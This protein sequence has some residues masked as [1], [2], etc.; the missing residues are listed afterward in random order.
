MSS[1][2]REAEACRRSFSKCCKQSHHSA[3]QGE[4]NLGSTSS[5]AATLCAKIFQK[6]RT[7]LVTGR[8]ILSSAP[9][10]WPEGTGQPGHQESSDDSGKPLLESSQ[11][12]ESETESTEEQRFADDMLRASDQ[13]TAL[14]TSERDVHK[15]VSKQ[16][17]SIPSG[18]TD[19]RFN[20]TER[21]QLKTVDGKPSSIEV[22]KNSGHESNQPQNTGRTQVKKTGGRKR[23]QKA[24]LNDR[25]PEAVQSVKRGGIPTEET[26]KAQNTKRNIATDINKKAQRVV[27]G[28]NG[29][30]KK[31]PLLAYTQSQIT[32]EVD[33]NAT[34]GTDSTAPSRNAKGGTK[35]DSRAIEVGKKYGRQSS[36]LRNTKTAQVKMIAKTGDKEQI[37]EA[38][39]LGSKT[40]KTAKSIKTDV[41]PTGAPSKPKKNKIPPTLLTKKVPSVEKE[42]LVVQVPKENCEPNKHPAEMKSNEKDGTEGKAPT[43]KTKKEAQPSRVNKSK[44][45]TKTKSDSD[46]AA[47]SRGFLKTEGKEAANDGSEPDQ[48]TSG[49]KT[50]GWLPDKFLAYVR[51]ADRGNV[52]EILVDAQKTQDGAVEGRTGTRLEK[53]SLFSAERKHSLVSTIK[54]VVRLCSKMLHILEVNKTGAKDDEERQQNG[55]GSHDLQQ[56]H[57]IQRDPEPNSSKQGTSDEFCKTISPNTSSKVADGTLDV[58]GT[59]ARPSHPPPL[60]HMK[61]VEKGDRTLSNHT[62]RASNNGANDRSIWQTPEKKTTVDASAGKM[63][64]V[65]RHGG[66]TPSSGTFSWQVP[67]DLLVS[68]GQR[69]RDLKKGEPFDAAPTN[70]PRPGWKREAAAS[71]NLGGSDERPPQ[72]Q[73]SPFSTDGPG[74]LDVGPK[75]ASPVGK[76][77]QSRKELWEKRGG[78]HIP[79]GAAKFRRR[80]PAGWQKRRTMATGPARLSEV[81]DGHHPPSSVSGGCCDSSLGD[82]YW[83]CQQG[84]SGKVRGLMRTYE[85]PQLKPRIQSPAER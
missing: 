50:A 27:P 29:E 40:P 31:S 55:S 30:S 8:D 49:N 13:D 51:L 45:K 69:L 35:R 47:K 41:L 62:T 16:P 38:T 79:A 14:F 42:G 39:G 63:Q 46:L 25:V 34:D 76:L 53:T 68:G 70:V 80:L 60:P 2:C 12:Q 18:K 23:S 85:T 4:D 66:E 65:P 82:D 48:N 54:Q 11:S 84:R 43:V 19:E 28:E 56:E 26:S 1:G 37:N 81:Q 73:H 17:P 57:I 10:W 75:H 71:A 67:R 21:T 59:L 5:T 20:S 72:H 78:A 32:A 6:A 9:P 36:Q 74:R 7:L 58:E 64:G 61:V 33:G 15:T 24:D 77:D 22:P 3:E 83:P 52:P 44:M